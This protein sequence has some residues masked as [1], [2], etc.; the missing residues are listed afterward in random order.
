MRR[1]RGHDL[2]R[3]QP[4]E[5]HADAVEMLLN[6]RSRAQLAQLLDVGRDVNWLHALDALDTPALAP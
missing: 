6:G 5:Q 4:V 1:I 3:H 2:A